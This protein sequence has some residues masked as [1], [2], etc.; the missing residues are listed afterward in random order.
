MSGRTT[1]TK[2]AFQRPF[3]IEGCD[4]VFKAGVYAV[5]TDEEL[6]EG[7]SFAAYRRVRTALHL[8]RFECK[9]GDGRTAIISGLAFDAA[10]KR[11]RANGDGPSELSP[12]LR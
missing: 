3:R 12:S 1:I 11:D 2:V 6:L 7:L 8:D 4:D 9:P 5:E 10:L